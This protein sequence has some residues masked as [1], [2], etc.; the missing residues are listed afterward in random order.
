MA[1]A[2][3]AA[4]S[5]AR[6]RVEVEE[7]SHL[8]WGREEGERREE[9]EGRGEVEG[10]VVGSSCSRGDGCCGYDACDDDLCLV[11]CCN[12]EDNVF[13]CTLS[14]LSSPILVEMSHSSC[15]VGDRDCCNTESTA[16][17]VVLLGRSSFTRTEK[18]YFV[19]L[20]PE[21]WL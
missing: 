5:I 14:L 2:D 17:T 6:L 10:S 4:R 3:V 8:E 18:G 19:I 12:A 20:F 11:P 7:R 9:D 16:L 13:L 1:V 15:T 21:R